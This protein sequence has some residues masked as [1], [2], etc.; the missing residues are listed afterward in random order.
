MS[1][2]CREKTASWAVGT[3]IYLSNLPFL[4]FKSIQLERVSSKQFITHHTQTIF[5]VAMETVAEK[6]IQWNF[7]HETYTKRNFHR[8]GHTTTVDV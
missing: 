3:H 7:I 1:R 6:L 2:L 8:S 5:S 4:K